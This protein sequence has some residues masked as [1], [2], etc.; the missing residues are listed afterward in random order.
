VIDFGE[1]F[2]ARFIHVKP[3][4]SEADASQ[5]SSSLCDRE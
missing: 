4:V 2:V 3:T 5:L 1:R